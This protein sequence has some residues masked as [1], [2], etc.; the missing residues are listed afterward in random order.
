M[1]SQS[2]LADQEALL[3]RCQV[4]K[5]DVSFSFYTWTDVQKRTLTFIDQGAVQGKPVEE[6]SKK[7][8]FQVPEKGDHEIHL[9]IK[10]MNF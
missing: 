6:K 4:K 1:S 10:M 8:I 9:D 2:V 3:F 5:V 7:Q